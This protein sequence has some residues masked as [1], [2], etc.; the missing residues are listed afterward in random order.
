MLKFLIIG[1]GSYVLQD[2][3]GPG[4][5]LRSIVQ[6]C[7]TEYGKTD[8]EFQITLTYHTQEKLSQKKA[9]VET[10]CS[11]M[12]GAN[13]GINVTF[14]S[15]SEIEQYCEDNIVAACFI[16]VP[17]TQHKYYI[18]MCFR[19]DLHCWVVKPLTG[20]IQEAAALYEQA[21]SSKSFVWLDYHKRFDPSNIYLKTS[22]QT[23]N[24]GKM[25]V[26][27]VDYHQ[28]RTLP[29]EVFN[30]AKDVDVF[31]YIGC[32]YVDQIFYLIPNALP[33]SVKAH[34]VKGHVYAATGQYDG[35][36]ATLEFEVDGQKLLCPFN[37]GWFNPTGSP[38][39]SLQ[40]LKVQFEKGLV[41]LDQTSR[42]VTVW[43]DTGVAELNP[44]FFREQMDIW[45]EPSIAGYGYQSV[46][47]FLDAV[48]QSSLK[49][50]SFYPT[51]SEA[52][53]TELVL[54]G[55]Q[56]SLKTQKTIAISEEQPDISSALFHR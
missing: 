38:T 54:W 25:L 44:Y 55:V 13:L 37:V 15:S 22:L 53:K 28:P 3:Y 17:D 36:L 18:D 10:I 31:T 4:V 29:M 30:W 14:I 33:V 48:T 50:G 6:W 26:Y 52:L 9:Q 45:G 23:A 20:N 35:V 46:K 34:P 43:D 21:K 7:K 40:R 5:V 32:H 49:Q 16:A 27:S 2:I 39:K 41:E 42:G 47:L 1:S 51:I 12:Q 8:T 19:R 56:Q 11:K 24:L